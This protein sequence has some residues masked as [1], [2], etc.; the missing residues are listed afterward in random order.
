MNP[1]TSTR[2][3]AIV[4]GMILVQGL[5]I[6]LSVFGIMSLLGFMRN[7]LEA[8]A[9]FYGHDL[10]HF[11]NIVKNLSPERFEICFVVAVVTMLSYVL[12]AFRLTIPPIS[13]ETQYCRIIT[14]TVMAW[15]LIVP[16]LILSLMAFSTAFLTVTSKFVQ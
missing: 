6:G 1:S 7:I 5:L 15:S 3:E 8:V 4:K 13:R 10:P 12:V 2:R 9:D 16:W 11:A 14:V